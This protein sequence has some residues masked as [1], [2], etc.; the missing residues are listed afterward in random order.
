MATR[1]ETPTPLACTVP[2]AAQRLGM[3]Q[4]QLRRLIRDGLFRAV[5]PPGRQRYTVPLTSIDEYL[6]GTS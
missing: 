4:Q 6:A 2:E 3:S 5:R 1:P